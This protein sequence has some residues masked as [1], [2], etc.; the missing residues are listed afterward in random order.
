MHYVQNLTTAQAYE[1]HAV[2]GGCPLALK[3]IAKLLREGKGL[4]SLL[5]N[6]KRNVT[7]TLSK[8]FTREEDQLHRVID[9]AFKNYMDHQSRK[10]ARILSLFPGSVSEEMANSVLSEIVD[11]DPLCIEN[12]T[13]LSFLEEFSI[14]ELRRFSIHTVIQGY[15][16]SVH[17]IQSDVKAFNSSFLS[18]YSDYLIIALKQSYMYAHA[19]ASDKDNY[20]LNDLESHN[21]NEFVPILLSTDIDKKLRLYSAIALGFLIHE[22]R[23]PDTYDY[24]VMLKAHNLYSTS[25]IFDSLCAYSSKEVC[26]SIFWKSC[27]FLEIQNGCNSYFSYISHIF[28]THPICSQLYNCSNGAFSY[29]DTIHKW[30]ATFLTSTQTVLLSYCFAVLLFLN[31]V[32][33][34]FLHKDTIV[35]LWRNA[36]SDSWLLLLLVLFFVWIANWSHLYFGLLY[37]TCISISG[38][39][40]EW[41]CTHLPTSFINN[42]MSDMCNNTT[43][44]VEEHGM[45]LAI[46]SQAVPL[47]VTLIISI[48]AQSTI[49]K[50]IIFIVCINSCI[51][52]LCILMFGCSAVSILITSPTIVYITYI[53][54][55]MLPLLFGYIIYYK[56]TFISLLSNNQNQIG[57]C[58]V[59]IMFCFVIMLLLPVCAAYLIFIWKFTKFTGYCGEYFIQIFFQR[60]IHSNNDQQN[61]LILHY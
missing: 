9:I 59:I 32:P 4:Q 22:K 24:E 36:P 13:R 12:V 20:L 15:L 39:V 34:A 3:V 30:I 28:F 31:S 48:V 57:Q 23:I 26:T 47:V 33:R 61:S 43:A 11:L 35:S 44:I 18:F 10:C 29:M 37:N 52:N 2:V 38:Y 5:A 19:N 42:T 6:L 8:K 17:V 21:M 58:I 27:S 1:L 56:N 16:K 51:F 49:N 14:E 55:N 45:F 25:S 54:I 50:K 53:L 41:Q 7:F 60:F 40:E 46:I